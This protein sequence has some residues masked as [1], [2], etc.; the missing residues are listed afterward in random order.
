MKIR[1]TEFMNTHKSR[2]AYDVLALISEPNGTEEQQELD[3]WLGTGDENAGGLYQTA[4]TSYTTTKFTIGT[5]SDRGDDPKNRGNRWCQITVSEEREKKETDQSTTKD[6]YARY[7]DFTLAPDGS[8]T[9][10]AFRSTKDGTKYSG[11]N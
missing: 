6:S 4:S 9:L 2:D 10:T 5:V 1:A 11:F 7:I 8:Y 3:F